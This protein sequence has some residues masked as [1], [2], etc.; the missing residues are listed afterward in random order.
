MMQIVGPVDACFQ[1]K[2]LPPRQDV[3]IQNLHPVAYAIHTH[4]EA[5][6]PGLLRALISHSTLP[7]LM[8]IDQDGDPIMSFL[9]VV[10]DD[11][12]LYTILKTLRR[13]GYD[14]D[15]VYG[16]TMRL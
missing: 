12:E 11:K 2:K 5:V 15:R 13:S 3:L 9:V 6:D 8:R 4:Q 16:S 14:F 7:S 10:P 1:R